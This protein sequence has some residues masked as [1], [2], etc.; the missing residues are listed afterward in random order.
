MERG[1]NHPLLVTKLTIPST[2]LKTIIPRMRLLY[3]LDAAQLP[4]ILVTA[5]AGFGKTTLIS[6]WIGQYEA[7]TAWLSLDDGDNDLFLFWRYVLKALEGLCP[8]TIAQI[9]EQSQTVEPISIETL[10]TALINGLMTL[11]YE[12]QLVLDNYHHISNPAIHQA[13]TFLLEYLPLHVHLVIIA[14]QEPPLPLARFRVR[15]QMVELRAPELRFTLDE[16]ATFLLEAMR[17]RLRKE[18]IAELYDLT[19][20]WIAGLQ[21]A[22]LSLQEHEELPAM[23]NTMRAFSGT[24]CHVQHYL[25]EE[26][27]THLSPEMQHF[28]LS[29]SIL[30][31]LNASLCD[32]LTEQTN[33]RE[34]LEW[35]ERA[36]IFLLALDYQKCWYRY[37]RLFRDLLRYYLEQQY[38][39]RIPLLH[40]RASWWFEQNGF[41][42][43]AIKHAFSATDL[44]RASGLIEQFAWSLLQL[45]ESTLVA[46]W[47]M[48]LPGH[49]VTERPLLSFLSAWT[50]LTV[51]RFAEY[52]QAILLA[53][54]IWRAEDNLAMLSRVF[55]LRACAAL[56]CG[57]GLQAIAYAQQALALLPENE[58]YVRSRVFVAL[59]AGH[60][61]T[62]ELSI[63]QATLAAGYHLSQ[64]SHNHVTQLRAATHLADIQLRQGHLHEAAQKYRRLLQNGSEKLLDYKIVASL[65]L[66]DLYRE[67]NDSSN[68]MAYWQQAMQ[69]IKCTSRE[70]DAIVDAY[71]IAARLAWLRA[72]YDQ[73][74]PFLEQA[75]QSA[76]RL[77]GHRVFLIQIVAYRVQ[78][79]LMQGDLAAAQQIGSRY[80][81]QQAR[82]EPYEAE[83]TSLLQARIAIAQGATTQ[84]IPALEEMVDLA[85]KQ[86]RTS[87]EILLLI[88]LALALRA[89]RKIEAAMRALERALTLAEP[90]GYKRIF[91]DEGTPV[92]SLLTEY[93]NR[94]H[95]RTIQD[96]HTFSSSYMRSLLAAFTAKAQVAIWTLA[97]ERGEILIEKL[98]E[99]EQEVLGLIAEGLSNQVVA[100]RLVV[101]VSTVKTH[102]NNIYTK[103]NVHT[104]LQAVTK[105]YDIGLLRRYDGDTEP[106]IRPVTP[107]KAQKSLLHE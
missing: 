103:L 70:E 45:E 97:P 6:Q 47:L 95:R 25:T 99:R 96:L 73:V 77:G 14:R 21:L 71:I 20:G 106:F 12:V 24:H 91:L 98:S 94:N 51:T 3:R 56:L 1:S 80:A 42:V 90:G 50:N 87:S 64:Q 69:M 83:T 88:V 78:Y 36:G 58:V 102:L 92:L 34:N 31:N 65:R 19:D 74:L 33:G 86:G 68:A 89:H 13:I 100:Q 84:T 32:S 10:L 54:Q 28:L 59:G 37:D 107:E 40:Q 49:I 41:I 79:L 76:H 15:G 101:T 7:E 26:V 66:A 39:E 61:L 57:N 9:E 30:D 27:W 43:D 104:R 52:E 53:E 35:L 67:W 8:A 105:A 85:C 2:A 62:G 38:P 55:D 81:I 46:T 82:Q 11:Q 48:L 22:A 75:E 4:L 72:E 23:V 44:E 63:A 16:A 29:T 18:D 93:H 60:I 17:L 5:P